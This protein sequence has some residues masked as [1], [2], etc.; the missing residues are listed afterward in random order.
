MVQVVSFREVDG[1]ALASVP[2]QAHGAVTEVSGGVWSR[3]DG[4]RL[5]RKPRCR[6]H[7]DGPSAALASPYKA[8]AAFYACLSKS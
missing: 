1:S 5:W 3:A 7:G 2:A 6:A 4:L 8:L